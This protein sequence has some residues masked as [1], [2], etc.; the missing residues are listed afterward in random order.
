MK[1][2]KRKKMK[3]MNLLRKMI[4]LYK[5][6]TMLKKKV[7]AKQKMIINLSKKNKT[8]ITLNPKRIKTLLKMSLNFKIKKMPILRINHQRKMLNPLLKIKIHRLNP[9]M[10]KKIK[11]SP[12]KL[13]NHKK[14]P[15]IK[16]SNPL[17]KN[18]SLP[19]LKK[20][21]KMNKSPLTILRLI[22]PNLKRLKT[23]TPSMKMSLNGAIIMKSNNSSNSNKLSNKKNQLTKK[24]KM[25][26][27]LAK[28]IL[29][30]TKMKKPNQK[31]IRMMTC[32]E[33]KKSILNSTM[34]RAQAM[35]L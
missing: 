31:K 2:Q 13:Q 6:P 24:K 27:I 29:H 28:K 9:L 8:T 10:K 7:K 5:S 12:M 20:P 17:M 22:T 3:M 18:K 1:N 25:T 21:K 4:L 30:K 32:L 34:I 33:V 15:I 14:N 11:I 19:M 16:N 35:W 23:K 26:G